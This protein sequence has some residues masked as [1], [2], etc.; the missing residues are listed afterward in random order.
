M[1]VP[2][3]SC[4]RS[5]FQHPEELQQDLSVLS[6]VP[7]CRAADH[8][9][10][11]PPSSFTGP[12]RSRLRPSYVVPLHRSHRPIRW[13]SSV[14]PLRCGMKQ[15]IL[16]SRSTASRKNVCPKNSFKERS[17]TDVFIFAFL[18]ACQRLPAPGHLKEARPSSSHAMKHWSVLPSRPSRMQLM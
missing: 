11:G 6:V 8:A 18:G 5:R 9:R 17:I 7:S 14:D 3:R 2:D 1:P 10:P 4:I 15:S 13:V 16:R 12:T